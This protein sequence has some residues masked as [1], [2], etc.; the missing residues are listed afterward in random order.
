MMSAYL[1]IILV[2]AA[3]IALGVGASS[4]FTNQIAAFF[5]TL[6]GLFFYGG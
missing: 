5:I 1:G 6:G 3:F 4:L 2:A